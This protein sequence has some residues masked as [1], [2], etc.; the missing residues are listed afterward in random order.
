[1]QLGV[2]HFGHFYLTYLLWPLIKICESVP[3]IINTSSCGCEVNKKESNLDLSDLSF[4]K[5]NINLKL[6][7]KCPKKQI[8]YLLDNFRRE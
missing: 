2:N 4:K 1:M 3:R 6:L 8:F 7:I 5:E